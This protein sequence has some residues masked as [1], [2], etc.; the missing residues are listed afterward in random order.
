MLVTSHLAGRYA[1]SPVAAEVYSDIDGAYCAHAVT[2]FR[3]CEY[4]PTPEAINLQFLSH[5]T[6][7]CS[8]P[9]CYY[10][11]NHRVQQFG[12]CLSLTN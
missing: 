8:H 11:G 4:A 6:V 5:P 10:S 3:A 12:P 7:F 1:V 9:A 2:R